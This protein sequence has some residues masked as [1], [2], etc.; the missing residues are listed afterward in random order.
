MAKESV[1]ETALKSLF[2]DNPVS[3]NH[4]V[5]EIAHRSTLRDI[6]NDLAAGRR[7]NAISFIFIG[8]HETVF[9]TFPIFF[10]DSVIRQ[11]VDDCLDQ[12]TS[13]L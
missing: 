6:V 10:L 1:G 9:K 5:D 4:S 12:A 8:I 2:D 11:R 3:L 13:I 7:E